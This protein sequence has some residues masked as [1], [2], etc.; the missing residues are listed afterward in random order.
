MFILPAR[1]D[2]QQ[3]LLRLSGLEDAAMEIVWDPWHQSMITA[4]GPRN[5]GLD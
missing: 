4:D 3:A 1:T 2:A 5:L